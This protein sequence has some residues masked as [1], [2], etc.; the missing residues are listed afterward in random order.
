[1]TQI[2]GDQHHARRLR[3]RSADQTLDRRRC[4]GIE[5]GGRLVQDQDIRRRRQGAG[6][7]QELLLA[8]G[9]DTRRRLRQM[10]E[11]GAL[12]RRVRAPAALRARHAGH[13]QGVLDVGQRRAAQ[14]HGALKHETDLGRAAPI[15]NSACPGH[16]ARRGHNQARQHAHE[17]ALA[18]TVRAD[19]DQGA[20]AVDLDVDAIENA[21]AAALED[22]ALAADRQDGAGTSPPVLHAGLRH[23]PSGPRLRARPS[24]AH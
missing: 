18:R 14:Q 3:P 9:Q 20:G 11:P 17:Q 12:E 15:G 1:M 7:R 16:L 23:R 5:V 21:P 8:A 4:R 19:Q 10:R 6:D 24:P 13:R 2:V 22:E